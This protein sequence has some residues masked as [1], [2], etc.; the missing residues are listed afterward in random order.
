MTGA[1]TARRGPLFWLSA[2][3]GWAVIGY[4]VRGAYLHRID[5]RPR[6]LATFALGGALLHDL[7]VAPLVIV[8]GVGV[9]RA[10]PARFR[11]VV[12]SA[13]IISACLILFSFPLV[14]GYGHVLH[15][16]SSLPHN[17]TANLAVMLGVVWLIAGGFAIR[18]LISR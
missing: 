4:G 10:T 8:A 17:Y 1:A 13:S 16:P 12:Q 9:A 2:A 14:R 6:D 3:V 11:S 5:T 18:R 7:V 15:N